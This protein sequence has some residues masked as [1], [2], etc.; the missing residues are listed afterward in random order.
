MVKKTRLRF[1]PVWYEA[2]EQDQQEDLQRLLWKLLRAPWCLQKV[3]RP[4][5]L[6][7]KSDDSNS[8]RSFQDT[9]KVPMKPEGCCT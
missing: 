7:H 6:D 9:A 2:G 4:S 3:W 1:E 8:S 5:A